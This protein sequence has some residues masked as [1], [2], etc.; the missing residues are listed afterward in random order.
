MKGTFLYKMIRGVLLGL[1]CGLCACSNEVLIER[2]GGHTDDPD[3]MVNLTMTVRVSSL[4]DGTDPDPDTPDE[5]TG[6]S[7]SMETKINSLYVFVFNLGES[8]YC[9]AQSF[10]DSDLGTKTGSGLRT[11]RMKVTPGNKRFY[12]VANPRFTFRSDL[13]TYTQAE[14]QGFKMEGL[15]DHSDGKEKHV[16]DEIQLQVKKGGGV[17]MT[18]SVTGLIELGNPVGGEGDHIYNGKL[19]LD[20]ISSGTF[21]LERAVAKVQLIC[22]VSPKVINE[23]LNMT[24][25]EILQANKTTYL[26]PKYI[27]SGADWMVDWSSMMAEAN[28][29]RTVKYEWGKQESYGEWKIYN[30]G[31][32]YLY[33]NYYGPGLDEEEDGL[34]DE[35]KYSQV[36]I[37]LSD[38]RDKTFP[39]AY[40][41]RNDFL[42]VTI[43]ILP[44]NIVCD[45]RPWNEDVVYPDYKDK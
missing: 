7:E 10:V 34:N 16:D 30:R 29:T 43:S 6:I 31:T 32:H 22:K 41:R 8:N 24:T 38:G 39:L 13:T 28:L 1:A 9:E 11:F 25:L 45:I 35:T 37:V 12:L 40:L 33:E 4:A 17:P 2:G 20:G 21:V 19:T 15:K 27:L 5:R 18:A 3:G 44:S 42:T 14:L 36:H 23:T 26:F